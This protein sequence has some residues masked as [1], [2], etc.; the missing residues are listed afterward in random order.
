MLIKEAKFKEVVKPVRERVSDEVHGCDEC[1]AVIDFNDK[2]CKYLEY[3]IFN[4]PLDTRSERRIL[5]SWKCVIK[6]LKKAKSNY[7][8]SLPFLHFDETRKGFRAK[9]FFSAIKQA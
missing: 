8:I 6:N 2:D 9:D 4:N 7:F 3:L 5:C 1:R